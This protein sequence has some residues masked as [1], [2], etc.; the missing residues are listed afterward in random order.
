MSEPITG[1]NAKV[2]ID[3]GGG[4]ATLDHTRKWSLSK[5]ADNAEFSDSGT[6][7]HKHSAKGQ[8]SKKV[9]IDCYCDGATFPTIE[10]GQ[11]ITSVKLYS[12]NTTFVEY[13]GIID[14]IDN[15]EGDIEG[16][17]MFGF[18]LNATLWPVA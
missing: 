18:T 6:G 7:G 4:P 5:S 3:T 2:V 14:S 11:S 12:D 13:R 9:T 17:G 15:I 10:E 1:I 16:S 8:K